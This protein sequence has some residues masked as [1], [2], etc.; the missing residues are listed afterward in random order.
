M[1]S[2]KDACMRIDLECKNTVRNILNDAGLEGRFLIQSTVENHGLNFVVHIDPSEK[3]P[4]SIQKEP[5]PFKLIKSK[6]LKTKI[7]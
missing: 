6:I 1:K 4:F 3:N 7:V 2:Y 5:K